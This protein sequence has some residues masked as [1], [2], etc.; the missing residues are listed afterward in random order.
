MSSNQDMMNMLF[1]SLQEEYGEVSIKSGDLLGYLGMQIAVAKD[2]TI[3]LSQPGYL[4]GLI[5]TF[6]PNYSEASTPLST[7]ETTVKGDEVYV[8]QNLYLQKVGS[9]NYLAQYTRPDILYAVSRAAQACSKPTQ[10]DMKRVD[11]IFKY[12]TKTYEYG[13]KFKK[14]PIELICFVDAAYNCYDD[15]KSHYGYCFAFGSNDGFFYGKSRKTKLTALSST[16]AEYIAI[17]E[18]TRDIVWLRRLLKEIGF[19]QTK[20]TT[21]YE[22]NMSCID[23][24][25]G[26]SNHK[27]S[28][29]INPKFHFVRDQVLLKEINVVHIPTGEMIADMLTK[30]LSKIMHNSF[31]NQILNLN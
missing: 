20:P 18:A 23:M 21:V 13:L 11:R 19:T 28:K 4:K 29:H 5:D 30:P 1:N 12:L 27:A 2:G 24:V 6:N 25:N 17:C 10:G 9:L 7:I 22:D 3:T 31:A 26:K 15:G 14:G 16:E 8:D